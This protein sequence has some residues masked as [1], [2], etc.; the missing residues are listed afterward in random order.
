MKSTMS[1]TEGARINLEDNGI[2]PCKYFKVKIY[3]SDDNPPH[4]HVIDDGWDI[5]FDI[6]S[7]ELLNILEE[8]DKH[9]I[10]NHIVGNIGRWLSHPCQIQP[11]ITNRENAMST[12]IQLH[13]D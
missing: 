1:N 12:W 11:K 7:G 9:S 10:F 2:F 13:D 3:S 4:L 8:G 5:T 6:Q